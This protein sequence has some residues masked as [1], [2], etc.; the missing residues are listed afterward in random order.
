MKRLVVEINCLRNYFIIS[1]SAINEN[2]ERQKPITSDL[3]KVVTCY[4]KCNVCF[5]DRQCDDQNEQVVITVVIL[6]C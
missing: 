6:N 4:I 3:Q 2:P 5:A 1:E